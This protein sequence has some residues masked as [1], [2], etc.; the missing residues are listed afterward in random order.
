MVPDARSCI[1][2]RVSPGVT[3]DAFDASASQGEL[4]WSSQNQAHGKKAQFE[5]LQ[6]TTPQ[7]GMDVADHH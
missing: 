5:L 7:I 2:D 3:P 6:A 4:L 1:G